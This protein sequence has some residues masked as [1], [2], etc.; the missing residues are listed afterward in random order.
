MKKNIY[1]RLF[2]IYKSQIQKGKFRDAQKTL[3][4]IKKLYPAKGWYHI[5]LLYPMLASRKISKSIVLKR[6]I[7][8]FKK[9]LLYDAMNPSAWRALGNTLFQLKR[10]DV[11]EKAYKQSLKYSR[12][13]LYKND[14]LRFLVDIL[15][16]KKQ[17]KK[18][19]RILNKILHSRHR[20]PYI[21]IANHFINYYQ[22]IGNQKMIN[23]WAKKAITSAKI[24]EKSGKAAYG[25]KNTYKKAIQYFRNF[26]KD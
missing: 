18:A 7:E 20:P 4:K 17:F 13:E 19:L 1:K 16:V 25:P 24:I 11:A 8:Y 10:Y 23:Y 12:S 14:A 3:L 9:S 21:Q 6:Q 5:G 26:I 22:K 15:V 2:Q